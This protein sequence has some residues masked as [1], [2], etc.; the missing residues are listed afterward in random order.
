MRMTPSV[1]LLALTVLASPVWAQSGGRQPQSGGGSGRGGHPGSSHGYRQGGGHTNG[2]GHAPQHGYGSGHYPS[3]HYRYNSPSPSHAHPGYAYRTH[4]A[5]YRL[6]HGYRHEHG[7]GYRYGYGHSYGY[8]YG[9][10][11]CVPGWPLSY[12]YYGGCGPL[13]GYRA[14]LVVTYQQGD[15]DHDADEDDDD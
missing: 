1:S 13:W 3:G 9:Y 4:Y 11:A 8:G 12:P 2:A 15:H 6:E 14:P 10:R 5:P 7:H